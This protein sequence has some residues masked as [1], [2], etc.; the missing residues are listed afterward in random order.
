MLLEEKAPEEHAEGRQAEVRWREGQARGGDA[1]NTALPQE[2]WHTEACDL[3]W[4][5]PQT[6]AFSSPWYSGQSQESRVRI[7]STPTLI[8]VEPSPLNF[9]C[10]KKAATQANRF[11]LSLLFIEL[12]YWR[13]DDHVPVVH[14][15]P[16]VL[17]AVVQGDVCVLGAQLDVL[18][19]GA[20]HREGKAHGLKLLRGGFIVTDVHEPRDKIFI[21]LSRGEGSPSL[22]SGL[23]PHPRP[24]FTPDTQS[25]EAAIRLGL[26][27]RLSVYCACREIKEGQRGSISPEELKTEHVTRKSLKPLTESATGTAHRRAPTSLTA[28]REPHLGGPGSLNLPQLPTG[29]AVPQERQRAFSSDETVQ[30][31]K[32]ASSRC[33]KLWKRTGL[34]STLRLCHQTAA[35]GQQPDRLRVCRRLGTAR[36]S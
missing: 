5:S 32:P 16:D 30:A 34:V 26:T 13:A 15:E 27:A 36:A 4:D 11:L 21:D 35:G 25:R 8:T 28:P 14:C 10:G 23:F 18:A 7:I 2:R 19:T 6:G 33:L 31:A 3:C 20:W 9:T 1:P 12:K 22:G 24:R 17:G 29:S